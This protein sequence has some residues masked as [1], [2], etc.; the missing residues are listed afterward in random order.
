MH[1]KG[2]TVQNILVGYFKEKPLGNFMCRQ[3]NTK[4]DIQEVHFEAVY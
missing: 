1:M 4:I 2:E 3:D